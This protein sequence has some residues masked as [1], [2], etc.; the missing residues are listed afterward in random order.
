M[1]YSFGAASMA[2]L[3]ECDNPLQNVLRRAIIISPFDFTIVTGHRNE[4]RQEAAF[5]AGHSKKHF[6]DSKHNS[7]P[8]Q[9]F[10]VAPWINGTITWN[11]EGSFYV[12]AGVILAASVMEGVDI[13]YGGDWNRNG[14]TEDQTFMDL[15]HFERVL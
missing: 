2:R 9:A 5:R 6:P 15:G 11:D 12:L 7:L 8:S 4:A 14:L 1:T 3:T 10:D 13:R